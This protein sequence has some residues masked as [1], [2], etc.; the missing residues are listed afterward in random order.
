MNLICFAKEREAVLDS[1]RWLS[2]VEVLWFLP[3][4]NRLGVRF[5]GVKDE[6][7]LSDGVS[8]RRGN[9]P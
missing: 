7:E 2:L 8:V 9:L 5:G 6:I 4:R 1:T 3:A